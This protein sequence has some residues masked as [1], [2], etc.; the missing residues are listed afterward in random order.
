LTKSYRQFFSLLESD[1]HPNMYLDTFWCYNSFVWKLVNIFTFQLGCTKVFDKDDKPDTRH[2]EK[3]ETLDQHLRAHLYIVIAQR[4]CTCSHSDMAISGDIWFIGMSRFS[5]YFT[6]SSDPAKRWISSKGCKTW[7]G[8]KA[9][10]VERWK[11][12]KMKSRIVVVLVLSQRAAP[13]NLVVAN[14]NPA[15][16]AP[17]FRLNL[18]KLCLLYPALLWKL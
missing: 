2:M 12:W 1:V 8:L 17:T 3:Q 18:H 6:G 16:S 4:W 9:A 13:L 15:L 14:V 5:S 7:E 11:K 10:T